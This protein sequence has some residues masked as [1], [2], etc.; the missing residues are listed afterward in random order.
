MFY[1]EQLVQPV[2][3]NVK[4]DCLDNKHRRSYADSIYNVI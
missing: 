4:Y 3:N 2:S 1:S